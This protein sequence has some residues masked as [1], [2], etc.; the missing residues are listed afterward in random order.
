MYNTFNPAA[1][2]LQVRHI[3]EDMAQDYGALRALP[4]C[5]LDA[6]ISERVRALPDSDLA[7]SSPSQIAGVIVR[8][9]L[10]DCRLNKPGSIVIIITPSCRTEWCCVEDLQDG[11]LDD[12]D[13]WTVEDREDARRYLRLWAHGDIRALR[14]RRTLTEALMRVD[15][16]RREAE[17]GGEA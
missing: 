9:I 16:P 2:R 10:R 7:T 14:L 11:D 4:Q 5:D 6:E 13:W 12:V 1:R 8:Q 15:L 3:A 17:E